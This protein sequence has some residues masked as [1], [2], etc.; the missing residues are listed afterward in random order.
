MNE[1]IYF[2]GGC[3]WGIEYHM[4]QHHGVVSTTVGYM[5]GHITNPDYQMVCQGHTGHLEVVK[6][7]YQPDIIDF[8]TLAKC[9]FEIH[10]PTQTDGQG[11]D[12]GPQYLSAVF[13]TTNQQAHLIKALIHR[14]I[15]QGLE[16]TTQCQP[17]DTFYPAE[18]HH[19]NYIQRHG[20]H[21]LCHRRV[22]RF[23]FD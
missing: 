16:V 23:T 2:A 5:G 7:V 10:D 4:Q 20:H 22:K 1:V 12:I 13:Y 17:A 14:L 8:N 6:V 9:F 15:Q 19:Q 3:F 21:V 11:A 18:N